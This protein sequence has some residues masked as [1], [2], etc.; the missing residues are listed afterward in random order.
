MNVMRSE[1]QQTLR[2]Q[3]GVRVDAIANQV[4]QSTEIIVVAITMKI[5]PTLQP[6]GLPSAARDF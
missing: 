4:R 6:T 5:S 2:N 1:I 3:D